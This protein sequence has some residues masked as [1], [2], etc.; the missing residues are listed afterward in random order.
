MC[1]RSLLVCLLRTPENRW[2][3]L[4]CARKMQ[5]AHLGRGTSWEGCA[6]AWGWEQEVSGTSSPPAAVYKPGRAV[7]V[8]KADGGDP[9]PRDPGAQV[10]GAVRDA[11]GS[12]DQPAC[13]PTGEKPVSA[14][15]GAGGRSAFIRRT[16]TRGSAVEPEL[17]STTGPSF[18]AETR[19]QK[20]AD[21]RFARSEAGLDPPAQNGPD[22]MMMPPSGAT[23][24]CDSGAF[25][26]SLGS[27]GSKNDDL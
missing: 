2:G 24:L 6:C 19:A 14:A 15:V 3:T 12:C 20:G 11:R 16:V 17:W 1:S 18:R 10:F 22:L 4:G 27:T 26:P 7:R 9:G 21:A 8:V 13:S 23:T 25:G 5:G